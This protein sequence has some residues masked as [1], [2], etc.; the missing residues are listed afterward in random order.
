[1]LLAASLL[2][3]AANHDGEA[4]ARLAQDDERRVQEFLTNHGWVPSGVGALVDGRPVLQFRVPG[5]I[6][7]VQ[8]SLVPPSGEMAS[9]FSQAAGPDDRVFYTYRGRISA[10]PPRFAYFHAK[11][12]DLMGALGFRSRA[13]PSVIAVSRPQGCPLEAAVPWSEL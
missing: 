11:V 1:M 2:G 8:V 12:A 10:D 4:D 5:C 13:R 3:K 9:L 6:G 7:T